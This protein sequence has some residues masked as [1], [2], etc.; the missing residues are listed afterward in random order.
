[1]DCGDL[2]NRP[3]G[4]QIGEMAHIASASV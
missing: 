2:A 4:L 3:D 1:M